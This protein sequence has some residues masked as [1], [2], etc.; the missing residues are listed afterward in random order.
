MGLRGQTIFVEQAFG[1]QV[2]VLTDDSDVAVS[3]GGVKTGRG[4]AAVRWVD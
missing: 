1:H 3:R 4:Q 2:M